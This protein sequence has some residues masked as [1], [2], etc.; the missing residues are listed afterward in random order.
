MDV[1]RW[2]R[3]KNAWRPAGQRLQCLSDDVEKYPA[4]RL[5]AD[6]RRVPLDRQLPALI[7]ALVL[8]ATLPC[9]VAQTAP[10]AT[11]LAE[12][13]RA[14]KLVEAALLVQKAGPEDLRKMEQI[15]S[16]L[17]AKYPG[18]VEVLNAHAEFLWSADKQTKAV[19][20]WLAAEKVDPRNAVILD[21]LGSSFL[22]AGEAKRAAVYFGRAVKSPGA[23]AAN[24]YNYANAAFLFRHEL[25]DATH[26]DAESM[27]RE[28]QV[29]FAEA[30]RLQPLD[31]EYARGYAETF[32]HLAQPDWTV[33]LG[34]WQRFYEVSPKKDFALLNLA[35][36]QIKLGQKEQAR[37]SLEKIQSPD[38]EKLKKKLGERIDGK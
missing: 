23:T 13:L 12:D 15:Y 35:R 21:H 19:A 1:V 17:A 37:E 31:P 7:V 28:A 34:A 3:R 5:R 2:G 14:A 36:V 18:N 11:T 26:P 30:S 38:F 20:V 4:T 16:G 33:A 9:A 27:L 8:A 25:L 10:P 32:Y 24:H 6:S 22:E 29:H